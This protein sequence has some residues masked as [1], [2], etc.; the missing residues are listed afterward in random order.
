M[1]EPTE[2]CASGRCYLPYE[3]DGGFVRNPALRRLT[4]PLCACDAQRQTHRSPRDGHGHIIWRTA[5]YS[6]LSVSRNGGWVLSHGGWCV[7]PCFVRLCFD[8]SDR[9][10]FLCFCVLGHGPSLVFPCFCVLPPLLGLLW[11]RVRVF[12]FSCNKHPIVPSMMSSGKLNLSLYYHSFMRPPKPLIRVDSGTKSSF[13]TAPC[14][15]IT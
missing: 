7:F 9:P 11:Q 15:T 13:S 12:V 8:P 3:G 6:L 2:G 5:P 10:V 14:F 4:H 1:T